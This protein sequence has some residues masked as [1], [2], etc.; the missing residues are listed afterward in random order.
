MFGGYKA[1]RWR[2]AQ[3]TRLM[4]AVAP[5]PHLPLMQFYSPA[6]NGGAGRPCVLKSVAGRLL[7]QA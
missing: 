7:P 4:A 1:R 3:P 6:R 2:V 5:G